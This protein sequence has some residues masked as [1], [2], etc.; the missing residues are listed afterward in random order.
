[1]EAYLA[2]GTRTQPWPGTEHQRLVDLIGTDA[3]EAEAKELDGILS[4]ILDGSGVR[5]A[6]TLADVATQAS[7]LAKT[8]YP[9]FGESLCREIGRY[10]SYQW[11]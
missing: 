4:T 8:L 6:K 7:A 1:M 10:A 9:D 3:A 2:A 11:K 5:D